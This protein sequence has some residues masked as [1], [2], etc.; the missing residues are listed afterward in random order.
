MAFGGTPGIVFE[1]VNTLVDFS[2]G[3]YGQGAVNIA[4]GAAGMGFGLFGGGLRN[5]DEVRDALQAGSVSIRQM[6]R[7]FRNG[8]VD[9]AGPPP[10][11]KHEAHHIFPVSMQDKFEQY[12]VDIWNPQYGNWWASPTHQ[13]GTRVWERT[14]KAYLSGERSRTEVLDY[15]RSMA[16][17]WGLELH[18]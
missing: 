13:Q 7:R 8:L 9:I 5:A 6:Q 11:A 18:F 4:A 3:D 2:R 10:T 14:W 1:G 17:D 16:R 15:G 12:G